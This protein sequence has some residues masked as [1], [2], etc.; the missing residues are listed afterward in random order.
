MS[1]GTLDLLDIALVCAD[2]ATVTRSES[3]NVVHLLFL[4]GLALLGHLGPR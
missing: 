1:T 3:S 2:A 4:T